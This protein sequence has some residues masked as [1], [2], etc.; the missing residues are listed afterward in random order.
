MLGE[1]WL[2]VRS[3]VPPPELMKT[4]FLSRVI[5]LTPVYED[6]FSSAMGTVRFSR[7]ANGRATAMTLSQDRVWKLGFVRSG[8]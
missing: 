7:E 6:A 2:P 8:S 4:L 3:E 1:H 5:V